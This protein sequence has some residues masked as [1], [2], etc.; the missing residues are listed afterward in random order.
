MAPCALPPSAPLTCV[1][2]IE[3]SAVGNVVETPESSVLAVH[4]W[5]G[6]GDSRVFCSDCS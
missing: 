1:R 5:L 4:N 2:L 3:Y 6:G